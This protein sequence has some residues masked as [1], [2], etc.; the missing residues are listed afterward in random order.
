MD[1]NVMALIAEFKHKKH[2]HNHHHAVSQAKE[3]SLAS[4]LQSSSEH[5]LSAK[6]TEEEKANTID[7]CQVANKRIKLDVEAGEGKTAEAGQFLFWNFWRKK[8][9]FF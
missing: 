6:T 9:H 8:I 5:S 3:Q 4:S 2:H 1:T 7:D